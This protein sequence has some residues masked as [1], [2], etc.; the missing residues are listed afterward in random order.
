MNPTAASWSGDVD[1]RKMKRKG[2]GF[3]PDDGEGGARIREGVEN[4]KYVQESFIFI[5]FK[6]ISS[7]LLCRY[8]LTQLQCLPSCIGYSFFLLVL[9]C[10]AIYS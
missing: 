6:R 2:G 3:S 9:P 10:S 7:L 4:M 1:G 8:T 5:H